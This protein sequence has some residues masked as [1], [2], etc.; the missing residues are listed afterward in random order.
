M[1][2]PRTLLIISRSFPLKIGSYSDKV[3]ETIKT[4]TSCSII[5]FFRKSCRLLDNV[6]KYCTAGQVTD[7][8][9]AQAHCML[10]I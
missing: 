6:E 10:G 5:S 3:V 1:T 7:D 2:Y 9:M 8:N 4:H